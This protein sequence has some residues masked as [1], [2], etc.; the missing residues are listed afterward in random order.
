MIYYEYLNDCSLI[1][2]RKEVCEMRWTVV[3]TEEGT[4]VSMLLCGM[5]AS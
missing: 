4:S 5:A 1:L 3:L 2:D